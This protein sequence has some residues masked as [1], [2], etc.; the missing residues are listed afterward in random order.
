VQTEALTKANRTR[1]IGKKTAQKT[2]KNLKVKA[3]LAVA[4]SWF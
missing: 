1:L 3:L 4:V 2:P